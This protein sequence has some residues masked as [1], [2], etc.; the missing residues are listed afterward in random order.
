MRVSLLGGTYLA[1]SIV[2]NAQRCVNLYPEKNPQDA[3]APVTHYPTPGL[4]LQVVPLTKGVGRCLYTATNGKLYYVCG[5]TVYYISSIFVQTALGTLATAATTPVSMVD[6]G[7]V[8]ILVDGSLVGYA[9]DLATNAFAQ[10]TDPNFLGADRVDYVDT[11]FVLN[12]PGTRNFYASLSN[13]TFDQLTGVPGRP[14]AGFIANAPTTFY[15]DGTY[16]AVPLVYDPAETVNGTGFTA[17]ITVAGGIVTAVVPNAA[18]ANYSDGDSLSTQT[19]ALGLP[20]GFVS[21]GGSAY[22]NGTYTNVVMTGGHG[23]KMLATIVVS[24]GVVTTCTITDPGQDYQN[25]DTLSA[26]S[27]SLGGPGSGFMF[28][29]TT[30]FVSTVGSGYT[31]GTYTL[32][33]VTGGSGTGMIATVTVSGG[34]VTDLVPTTFGTGYAPGDTVSVANTS[35]GGTGTGMVTTLIAFPYGFSWSVTSAHGSAFDPTYVASKT[36]FPD[37]IATLCC[38]H[39]E[40]WLFGIVKTAE[41]WYDAGG[42]AFPFAIMPGVFIEHGCVA[43][44]SVSK[45]D[46]LVFWLST[47]AEGQGTVFMGAGYVARKI[48]TPAIA[49]LIASYGSNLSDAIGMMYKQ[50]D[51]VFYFLTFPA[52]NKTLVYDLTENLWHERTWTNPADGSENRHRANCMAIAY[53]LVMCADW[54]NGNV[55]QLDLGTFN[56]YGGPIVRRRGFPHLTKEL[57][58]TTYDCFIADMQCGKG[59]PSD[60]TTAQTVQ[61]RWS[62]DRGATFGNPVQQSIGMQGEYLVTP[63]WRQLGMARD[64]VFELYWSGNV[65]TAL[66][67]AY[68]DVTPTVAP[69]T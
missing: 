4:K 1:R 69:G 22:T 36:G 11:F 55:Y 2:A 66:Q 13:V 19:V 12:Q 65:F 49:N 51:H 27:T 32:V 35:I 25:R 56:D 62:D 17:D 44:Y 63:Q 18:G 61:L 42:A 31:N 15:V 8:I 23:S 67:G 54:E 28:L 26:A 10:I 52:A 7:N 38:V 6:N 29:L 14:Y 9:I 45:H 53:G 59:D 43:K 64:R 21:A 24:G 48:S 39:R 34:V 58:R 20:H 5:Q 3:E 16:S 47:D 57:K 41:V 60:P 33:P 46:L 37:E 30:T 50:Q 40:I 68:V